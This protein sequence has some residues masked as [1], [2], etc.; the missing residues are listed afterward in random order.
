MIDMATTTV[1]FKTDKDTKETCQIICKQLGI[2]LSTAINIFLHQM[3]MHDG[4]PFELKLVPNE[5]TRRAIQEAEH[6][7][8]LSRAYNSVEELMEDLDAEDQDEETVRKGL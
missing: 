3:V 1:T 7:I 4:L 5:E 6:G 8:G 2:N